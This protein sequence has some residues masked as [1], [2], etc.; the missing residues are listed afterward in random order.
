[1]LNRIAVVVM[2]LVAL[3]VGQDQCNTSCDKSNCHSVDNCPAGI[4]MDSCN[5]CSV[6]GRLEGEKC[7]NYTLPLASGG[8]YGLCG[9]NMACLLRNNDLD[10]SVS[11]RSI[12]TA[13]RC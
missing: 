7:D 6:C 8:G 10:D 9:D 12:V 2:V 11:L 4:V 5:C 1:M 3:T 13:L